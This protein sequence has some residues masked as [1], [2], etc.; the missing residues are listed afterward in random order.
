METVGELNVRIITITVQI[1]EHY[2]ELYRNLNEMFA[3]LPIIESPVI[4]RITLSKW[5]DSLRM[6]VIQY[7]AMRQK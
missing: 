5:L 1:Q 7:D 3:T 2:P 4:N 6:L